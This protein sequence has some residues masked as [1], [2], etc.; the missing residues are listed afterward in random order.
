MDEVLQPID[1]LHGAA[2]VVLHHHERFDGAGYPAGLSGDQLVIGA[3]IF[4]VV[5][6]FANVA[7]KSSTF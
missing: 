4:A 6:Y 7:F 2:M 3:R 5:E 1:F